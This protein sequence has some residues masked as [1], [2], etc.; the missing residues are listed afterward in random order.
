MI[1]S[2]ISSVIVVATGTNLILLLGRIVVLQSFVRILLMSLVG[3]LAAASVGASITGWKTV[4]MLSAHPANQRA[5]GVTV[6]DA[7]AAEE[8]LI[9]ALMDAQTGIY[10]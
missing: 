2:I 5:I 8:L 9:A 4:Q 7:V 1:L 3:L 10:D 6:V